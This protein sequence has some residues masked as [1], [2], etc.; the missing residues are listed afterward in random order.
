MYFLIHESK[1]ENRE[2]GERRAAGLYFRHRGE[3][4]VQ[5]FLLDHISNEKQP[6][7]AVHPGV[8][9]QKTPPT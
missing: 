9:P 1:T 4:E 5:V 6:N 8:S 2:E 7:L 3:M